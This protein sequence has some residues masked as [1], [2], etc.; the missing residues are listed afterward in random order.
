MP[1]PGDA[2]A[3]PTIGKAINGGFDL[4]EAKSDL[5]RYNRGD[6]VA[7]IEQSEPLAAAESVYY[8]ELVICLCA[9][10]GTDTTVVSE[11]LASELLAVG[12]KPVPVR[13]SALMGQIPVWNTSLK[14]ERRMIAYGRA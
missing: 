5:S 11:A 8:P 12:Y 9:A 6:M 4:L 2:Q 7:E 3:E 10:V 1:S 13:L 14:L